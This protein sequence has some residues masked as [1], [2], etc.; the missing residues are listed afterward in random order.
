MLLEMKAVRYHVFGV[1]AITST[2]SSA[3]AIVEVGAYARNLALTRML[4][5]HCL[6]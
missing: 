1:N 6:R 2:A 3:A 5:L 4:G